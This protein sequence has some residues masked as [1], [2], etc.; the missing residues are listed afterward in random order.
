MK[1]KKIYNASLAFVKR[2]ANSSILFCDNGIFRLSFEVL[3]KP[4]YYRYSVTQ[5]NSTTRK[6]EPVHS[7]GSPFVADVINCLKFEQNN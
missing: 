3:N 2:P 7:Y 1:S 4:V 5:Y 6:F